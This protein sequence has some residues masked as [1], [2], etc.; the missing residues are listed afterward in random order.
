MRAR[1]REPDRN[2]RRPGPLSLIQSEQKQVRWDDWLKVNG[3]NRPLNRHLRFDRSF[4]ALAA[5]RN[6][7]GIAFESVRLAEESLAT[8]QLVAPFARRR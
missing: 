7:L 3:I 4:M 6:E 2:D 1:T 8:G 5:A